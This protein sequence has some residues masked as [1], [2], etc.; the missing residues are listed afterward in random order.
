MSINLS[1]SS[2]AISCLNPGSHRGIQN[3]SVT[4][5]LVGSQLGL[6]SDCQI[7]FVN[8]GHGIKNPLAIESQRQA[9]ANRDEDRANRTPPG[10]VTV[11]SQTFS[12][13]TMSRVISRKE[14]ILT[15]CSS[16][17]WP[18]GRQLHL[19]RVQQEL[20][21]AAATQPSHEVSQRREAL[22]L[23]VLRERFQRH[24]RPQEAH[25]DA[26]RGAA[27]QVLPLRKELHAEVLSRESRSKGPRCAA[28]VRVQGTA[29]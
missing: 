14:A 2:D 21:P 28:S 12:V 10:K 17:F 26:H 23:H 15:A 16:I 7:E 25:E 9:A 27:V 11:S 1:A 24:V 8:G 5:P 20:Q 19:P 4:D 13:L 22:S 18:A 3:W 29:R 6:P